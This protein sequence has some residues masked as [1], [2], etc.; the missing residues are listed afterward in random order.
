M[1]TCP[2]PPFA[3]AVVVTEPVSRW[4]VALEGAHSVDAA[5]SLAQACHGLHSSTARPPVPGSTVLTG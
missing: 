2:S 4:A 3:F 5:G 1:S